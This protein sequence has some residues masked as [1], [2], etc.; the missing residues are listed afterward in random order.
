VSLRTCAILLA[1]LAVSFS[2]APAF[3]QSLAFEAASIKLSGPQS[4]RGSSGGP[5]SKDTERYTFLAASLH[6]LITVAW[7]VDNFQVLSRTYLDAP[8]FDLTATIPPGATKEQFRVMLQN[9]L[10]ERFGLEVHVESR[11][12]PAYELVVAK[13][14]FKLKEAVAGASTPQLDGPEGRDGWPGLRPG[15]PDMAS[16]ASASGGYNLVRLRGREQSIAAFAE[17]LPVPGYLPVVDKTGI[18][19]K[20]NF[21]LEYTRDQPGA[22]PDA[23]PI[24][25]DL[26]TV[27]QRQLGLQLVPKKL[28]F[29]V[30][31]VDSFNRLPTGN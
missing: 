13:G 16:N 18:I 8:A 15:R 6:D 3:S 2:R 21:A 19:G 1:A 26:F 10:A 11:D 7:H 30:V 28:P 23:P 22:L 14:G 27:M 25:P 9:L 17:F 12:F 4:V 24:V 20:Y 31:V 5:G 29:D